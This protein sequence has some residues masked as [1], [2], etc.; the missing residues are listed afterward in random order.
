MKAKAL[1]FCMATAMVVAGA[2]SAAQTQARE[3]QARKAAVEKIKANQRN[4][5]QPR[6]MA[7][8]SRTEARK[9]DGTVVQAVPTEL[10][11]EMSAE[12]DADGVLRVREAD[13]TTTVGAIP[14]ELAHE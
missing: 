12:R 5:R 13:A 4:F 2:A 7:E 8:A 9:A 3:A 1:L 10:W 6:T 11:N 14:E